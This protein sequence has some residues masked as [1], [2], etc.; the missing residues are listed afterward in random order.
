MVASGWQ[1]WPW[2]VAAN[3]YG[4]P[5]WVGENVLI[6][7]VV[8]VVQLCEYTKNHL[9]KGWYVNY[10]SIKLLYNNLLCVL[11]KWKLM[12]KEERKKQSNDDFNIARMK[13]TEQKIGKID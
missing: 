13:K 6:S 12:N 4:V 9:W 7:R 10:M 1:R 8:I 2:G 11:R 3:G 5:L